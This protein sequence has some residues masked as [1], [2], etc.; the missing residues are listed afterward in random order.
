MEKK[1]TKFVK[2]TQN[3]YHNYFIEE[4]LNS[5]ISNN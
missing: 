4:K 3:F 1:N 2:D 5:K